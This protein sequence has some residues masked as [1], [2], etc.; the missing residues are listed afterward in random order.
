[1]RR[2]ARRARMA[3]PS[4][5][6]VV[7]PRPHRRRKAWLTSD[8]LALFFLHLLVFAIVAAFAWVIR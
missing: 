2:R 7:P 5:I 3:W 4:W 1:M 8:E 6:N